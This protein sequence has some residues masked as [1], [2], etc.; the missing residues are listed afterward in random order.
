MTAYL[1]VEAASSVTPWARACSY[2]AET[3][4]ACDAGVMAG[5]FLCP[6]MAACRPA[7]AVSYSVTAARSKPAIDSI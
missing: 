1:I 7:H 3:T 5:S 4:A 2:S 6:R